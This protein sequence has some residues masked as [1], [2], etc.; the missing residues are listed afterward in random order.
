M[1]WIASPRRV[2]RPRPH[3]GAGGMSQTSLCRIASA[4]VPSS[5][6]G[7]GACQPANLAEDALALGLVH[8]DAGGRVGGR[9]P[10]H[11]LPVHAHDAEAGAPPPC[12]AGEAECGILGGLHDAAPG[13]VARVSQRQSREERRAHD[14]ADPVRAHEHVRVC[15]AAVLED[16]GRLP[17]RPCRVAWAHRLRG[18]R[19]EEDRVQE[20]TVDGDH[21]LAQ[22]A[23]EPAGVG[24]RET[25]AVRG[26]GWRSP[27]RRRRLRSPPPRPRGGAARGWRSATG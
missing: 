14:R 24:L 19:L 2:T 7:M 12:L 3:V 17:H 21:G 27:P 18:Q 13:R 16:G 26:A 11:P 4:G 15:D 1:G 10:I 9:V 20:G 6:A 22:G 8:E 5:R 23:R 25:Q